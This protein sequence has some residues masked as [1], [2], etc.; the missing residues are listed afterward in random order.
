MS[1]YEKKEYVGSILL[2]W[3]S[4]RAVDGDGT[5]YKDGTDYEHVME[6]DQVRSS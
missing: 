6:M 2:R 1:T 4:L 5:G 3:N